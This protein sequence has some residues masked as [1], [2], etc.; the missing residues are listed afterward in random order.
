MT[1]YGRGDIRCGKTPEVAG[2]QYFKSVKFV[3]VNVIFGRE[4]RKIVRE[5]GFWRNLAAKMKKLSAKEDFAWERR[6][7]APGFFLPKLTQMLTDQIRVGEGKKTVGT[8]S[9][10][11]KKFHKYTD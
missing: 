3:R 11:T 6:S 2:S 1:R 5:E 8:V 10:G 9:K 4:N 7:Q